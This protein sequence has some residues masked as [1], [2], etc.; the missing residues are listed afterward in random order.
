MAPSTS[1]EE[2]AK[3]VQQYRSNYIQLRQN[4]SLQRYNNIS[5]EK[6]PRPVVTFW[7]DNGADED[8]CVRL[9]NIPGTLSGEILRLRKQLPDITGHYE[10]EGDEIRELE[11]PLQPPEEEE[12]DSEDTTDIVSTLPLVCVDLSKHFVKSSKYRSEVP[13][14]LKCQG[15]TCPGEPLSPHIIQLLGRTEDNQIVFPRFFPKLFIR[16]CSIAAYKSWILQIIQGLET[17]HSVNIVHRDL[18]MDNFLFSEDGKLLLIC[19]LES[20]W[21]NRAAPEV[22][23]EGGEFDSGWSVKSDIFDIGDCIKGMVYANA[24]FMNEVEW[25]VPPPFDVLVDVCM[26][27]DPNERPTLAELKKMVQAIDDGEHQSKGSY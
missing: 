17:L 13:N 2:F 23:F 5:R 11:A 1:E 22:S 14:L 3:I 8:Q 6:H 9:F 15:G 25:Q 7:L 24:P 10:I 21:G 27:E 4:T 20:R 16:F 18:R 12:D 26:R 19:D